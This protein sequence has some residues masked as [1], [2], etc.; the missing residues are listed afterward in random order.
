M[1][2]DGWTDIDD[3]LTGEYLMNVEFCLNSPGGRCDSPSIEFIESYWMVEWGK[4]LLK[5]N[6]KG[7]LVLRAHRVHVF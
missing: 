6:K 4:R 5:L 3:M 2:N 1:K 7:V